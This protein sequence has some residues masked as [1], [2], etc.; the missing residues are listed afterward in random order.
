MNKKKIFLQLII[1]IGLLQFFQINKEN[2]P[3]EQSKDFITI[4][5]P[6]IEISNILKASCYDCHSHE[7]K[8]P[9]YT[10]VSPLSWWL[11]YHINDGRKHLNF[12]TWTDYDAKKQDHKLEECV[13]E[14][15]EGEMPLNSYLWAHADAKL[16]A[17]QLEQ[18]TKFFES[19]RTHL[20]D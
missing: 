5:N 16:T 2:P 14:V 3:I 4:N 11:R 6:P 17:D 1:V 12:S 20:S 18:L 15:G 19:K 8:Y 10:S 9:W 7:T 13:E